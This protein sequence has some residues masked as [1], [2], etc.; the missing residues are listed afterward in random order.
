MSAYAMLLLFVITGPVLAAERV[1]L[2]TWWTAGPLD[3]IRPVDQAPRGAAKVANLKAARN[4]FEPFQVALRTE[5][6]D[7]DGIDVEVSDFRGPGGSRIAGETVTVY[8]EQFIDLAKPSSIDGGTGLWPDAL[9]PRTDRYAHERRNA[10]PVTLRR[11]VTQPLWFEVY[12][13]QTATPGKY[14]A[15]ATISRRGAPEFTIPINLAVWSFALPSTSSF[16]TTFGLNGVTAL[17]QHRGSYTSDSD[18]F[19]LTRLYAK[20]AL[21][22]RISTHGGSMAPPKYTCDGRRVSID[23]HAYDGEVAPLLEGKTVSGDDPLPGARATTVEVRAPSSFDSGDCESAYYAAWMK[24]FQEKGWDSRLFLY[25]WDEPKPADASKVADH[26]RTVLHAAPA[27]LNLITTPFTA[28]LDD[29]VRIWVPLVNCLESRPSFANYCAD[30]PPLSAYRSEK[31]HPK[32]LWF[33]QSCASHGCNSAGG[34]YFTGWPSYMIDAPGTANRVMPWVAWK[35]NIQGELYYNMDEAYAYDKDPWTN[36]RISG[37]NGD[38]TLFYPGRP[39]RIGGHSDIPIESIRLKLIREGLEDYEYL[40][41]AAKL[42]GGKVADD[43][44]ARIVSQPYQWE[45]APEKFLAVR[46]EL[47]DLLDSLTRSAA[48]GTTHAQQAQQRY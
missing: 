30:Q 6:A 10:F 45:S 44:A 37:G 34:P 38:G 28:N 18:L 1:P 8:A 46:A 26:A 17:K 9:I 5:A 40:A 22:H 23:W 39:N 14:I 3:K 20:A 42:G 36:M 2:L 13:P 47:G 43:F 31:E 25:L 32:A 7:I 29:L 24:H 12:V 16:K 19:A 15:T 41:L 21:L 35:F 11:G 33:Y 4:E 27:L 48:A